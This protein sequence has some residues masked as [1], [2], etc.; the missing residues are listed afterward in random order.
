MASGVI[1]GTCPG[2]IPISPVMDRVLTIS[3]SF[4]YTGPSG[5]TILTAIVFKLLTPLHPLHFN[6]HFFG[7]FQDIIDR[8]YETE[9]IF[10]D[11]VQVSG[12]NFFKAA[13]RLFD[14]NIGTGLSGKLFGDMEVLR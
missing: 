5:V 6:A 14:R 12:K 13:Y 2:R 11:M 9:G 10:R 8:T 7:F 4:S 3:T 1:S